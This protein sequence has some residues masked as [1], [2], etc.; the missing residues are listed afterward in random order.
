[1]YMSGYYNQVNHNHD[2]PR[3]CPSCVSV[4]ARASEVIAASSA[5]V[6]TKEQMLA[7]ARGWR[8][9]LRSSDEARRTVRSN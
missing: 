3:A 1:M 4:S 8:C 5:H 2:Q 6:I 9:A 7:S